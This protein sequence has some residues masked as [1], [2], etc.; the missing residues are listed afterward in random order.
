VKRPYRLLVADPSGE[1][2]DSLANVLSTLGPLRVTHAGTAHEFEQLFEGQG[3]YDLVL[4]RSLFGHLTGLQVLAK[5]RSAGSRTSFIVYTSLEGTW[6]RVF[7][8]DV[9]NTV[10]SS[11]VVSLEGLAHLAGGLLEMNR[12]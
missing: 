7:V 3:P 2:R 9:E 10:L 12:A 8:S 4:C 6:L 1:A 11:R 5:A